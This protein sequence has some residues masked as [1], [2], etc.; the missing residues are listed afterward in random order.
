MTQQW[1]YLDVDVEYDGGW[2]KP[3]VAPNRTSLTDG[4]SGLGRDG[5]ELTSTE[6]MFSGQYFLRLF[7]KRPKP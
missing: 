5:W 2:W 3:P 6:R 4:C 7:F 1:E